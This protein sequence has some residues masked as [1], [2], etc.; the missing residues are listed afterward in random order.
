MQQPHRMAP[1][2]ESSRRGIQGP[3]L[4][5]GMGT[6]GRGSTELHSTAQPV[7]RFAPSTVLTQHQE[8]PY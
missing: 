4:C 7:S 6:R 2:T 1:S 3:V 8:E 5:E